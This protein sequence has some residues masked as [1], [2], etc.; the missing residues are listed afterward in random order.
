MLDSQTAIVYV[1]KGATP[2]HR[3][4]SIRSPSTE[5]SGAMLQ[6]GM[7]ID[8]NSGLISIGP[9]E[10]LVNVSLSSDSASRLLSVSPYEA[11]TEWQSSV[12]RDRYPSLVGALLATERWLVEFFARYQYA[13]EF[14]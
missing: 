14:I 3:T 12:L 8:G 2:E 11:K 4:L 10:V 13:V 6:A 1:R 9:C 7:A 5:I